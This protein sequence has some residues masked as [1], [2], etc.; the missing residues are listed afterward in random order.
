ME[1]LCP[2]ALILL[3]LWR[4]IS[5]VLTYLLAIC[6]RLDVGPELLWCSSTNVT[7]PVDTLYCCGDNCGQTY[8]D[9]YIDQYTIT[10]KNGR[11]PAPASLYVAITCK[12][13]GGA[14]CQ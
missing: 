9:R 8:I 14:L 7:V 1:Y 3:R 4:Y 2:H 11:L 6:I 10:E 5:Q 13:I 12:Q